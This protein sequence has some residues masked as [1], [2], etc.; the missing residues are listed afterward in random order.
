MKRRPKAGIKRNSGFGLNLMTDDELNEIHLATLEVLQNTG[1]F[2]ENERA[3]E[4][5][6]GAGCKVDAKNKVVK[7]PHYIVEDAIRTA[8]S[9]FMA[10]GRIPESDV[11]LEDNRVTLLTLAKVSCSWIRK[12]VSIGIPPRPI[13]KRHPV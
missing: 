13:S 8:P 4:V 10:Y 9:T 6:H 3:L 7:I 11:A 12:P 1:V 5:Y 2:V